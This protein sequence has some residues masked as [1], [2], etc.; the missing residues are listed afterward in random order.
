MLHFCTSCSLLA[1]IVNNGITVRGQ[2]V[3]IEV[4]ILEVRPG[5]S[6]EIEPCGRRPHITICPILGKLKDDNDIRL[7]I[8]ISNP[9]QGIRRE[10]RYDCSS[11]K[12]MIRIN[13][14]LP[15]F[16]ERSLDVCRIKQRAIENVRTCVIGTKQ[17]LPTKPK[18]VYVDSCNCLCSDYD[19]SRKTCMTKSNKTI[20][21]NL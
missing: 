6:E 1:V 10:V 13:R 18:L 8:R 16:R 11:P 2:G 15:G 17:L 7:V 12:M 4:I 9:K 20:Q 21:L 3:V 19:D 14:L 5:A